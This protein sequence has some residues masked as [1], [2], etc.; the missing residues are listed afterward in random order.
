MTLDYAE[1][2]LN[3][4]E[5]QVR[6]NDVTDT[7]VQDA[8]RVVPRESLLPPAKRYMAYAELN[9]EY[10][11][12]YALMQPRDVSKL[13]QAIYPRR[14]ERAMCLAAPYA[15]LV[16]SEM[17][18]DVTLRMPEGAAAEA[19]RGA[20]DGKPVAFEAGDLKAPLREGPYG[21][22]IS[23]GAVTRAP[24]SWIAGVGVGGRLGVVE[25][26]GPVGKARLYLRGL[27][28][29]VARREVFDSTP[30]VLPGFEPEPVFAF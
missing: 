19:V 24:E 29:I 10:A 30:P 4:V 18:L 21:V 15:A 5:T 13:L 23:E 3:M 6:T 1:A 14:G 16:L 27:D 11:P 25:R 8:M 20:F 12:G 9:P 2:R 7:D 26:N 28:G 22:L 17:G